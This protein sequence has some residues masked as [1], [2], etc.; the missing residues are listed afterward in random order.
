MTSNKK[1]KNNES[2]AK[3]KVNIKQK[4]NQNDPNNI[5]TKKLN[6]IIGDYGS[7]K[8]NENRIYELVDLQTLFSERQDRIWNA[9]EKTISI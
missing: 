6:R 4:N 7:S 5:N 3:R 1:T 8:Q 9:L 2:A